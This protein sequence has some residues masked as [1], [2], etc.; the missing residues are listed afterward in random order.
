M[1]VE[2]VARL[3]RVLFALVG[4]RLSDEVG[5]IGSQRP[6]DW[7][8]ATQRKS[9]ALRYRVKTLLCR[10]THRSRFP[11]LAII[12]KHPVVDAIFRLLV[13]RKDLRQ[14]F[15]QKVVIWRFFEAKLSDIVE[16]DR[17][18]LYFKPISVSNMS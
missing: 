8:R 11:A 13:V 3:A 6:A 4:C 2:R 17:E 7:L 12:K 5:R 1:P 16:V 18:F 9:L 10:N 14:K 15:S